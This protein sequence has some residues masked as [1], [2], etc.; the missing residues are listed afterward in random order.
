[1]SAAI[2]GA[3]AGAGPGLGRCAEELTVAQ[4]AEQAAQAV[5]ALNHLTRPGVGVL[6][7]PAQ[8]AELVAVL[9]GAA[10]GLPQLLGQLDRWLVA[11]ARAGRLRVDACEDSPPD[12]A[13]TVA[14]ATDALARASRC[15]HDAGR[16]LDAAHQHLALLAATGH[17]RRDRR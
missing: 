11:Q 13:G 2:T 17:Q 9:A 14:A 1:V 7:Q 3:G 5:R 4:L 10:G 6:L 15:A 12:P 8:V 16:A